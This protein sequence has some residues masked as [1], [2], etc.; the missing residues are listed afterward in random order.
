MLKEQEFHL[1]TVLKNNNSYMYSNEIQNHL[2]V[3]LSGKV[4]PKSLWEC[5]SSLQ[6]FSW[7]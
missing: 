4:E 2:K 5:R 6:T 1:K 3:L 7:K